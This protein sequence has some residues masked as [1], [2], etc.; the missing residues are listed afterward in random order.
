MYDPEPTTE[1]YDGGP[2]FSNDD[3]TVYYDADGDQHVVMNDN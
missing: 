1:D 2:T 3:T